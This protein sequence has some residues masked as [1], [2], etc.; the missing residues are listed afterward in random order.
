IIHYM[1]NAS[2]G[3]NRGD[4]VAFDTT[5]TKVGIEYVSGGDGLANTLL[6]SEKCGPTTGVGWWSFSVGPFNATPQ[7]GASGSSTPV[8]FLPSATTGT[9]LSG[10]VVNNS[11]FNNTLPNSQHPGGAMAAFCDAHTLFIKD[12]IAPRVLSQLMTSKSSDAQASYNSSSFT[13]VLTE[14]DVK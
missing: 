9:A 10:K 11:T 1:I 14:A 6:F 2:G 8:I 4:A 5:S 13:Y 7:V 3:T 12:S